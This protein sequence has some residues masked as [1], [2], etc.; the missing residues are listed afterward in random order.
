MKEQILI[1]IS[2][3]KKYKEKESI[4]PSLVT[5]AEL[6][7][8]AINEIEKAISELEKEGVITIGHTIN[9]RFIMLKNS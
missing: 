6:K 4:S 9:D 8:A 3:S 7:K 2:E 5:I 1:L